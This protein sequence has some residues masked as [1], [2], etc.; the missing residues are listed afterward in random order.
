MKQYQDPRKKR[1]RK[2]A[3]IKTKEVI[4]ERGFEAP[5]EVEEGRALDA[6]K[7][8]QRSKIN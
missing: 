7:P 2:D 1:P 4:D 5:A 6:M 8:L 3:E